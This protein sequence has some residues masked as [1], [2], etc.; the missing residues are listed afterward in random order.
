M[1]LETSSLVRR[2]RASLKYLD[3]D[4]LRVVLNEWDSS[5]WQEKWQEHGTALQKM[6]FV[7][8]EDIDEQGV[9]N[10][11]PRFIESE[12]HLAFDELQNKDVASL[13]VMSLSNHN[14]KG[15]PGNLN[16]ENVTTNEL[17]DA[18]AMAEEI[19]TDTS[20]HQT[21]EKMQQHH[22]HHQ[23]HQLSVETR[24]LL[25]TAKIVRSVRTSLLHQDY[26]ALNRILSTNYSDV[27]RYSTEIKTTHLFDL[28]YHSDDITPNNN[29][30]TTHNT[31]QKRQ[32]KSSK[33]EENKEEDKKKITTAS[34]CLEPVRRG[35][36]GSRCSDALLS[37]ARLM[38]SVK[39]VT[40]GPVS[41]RV[42]ACSFCM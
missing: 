27:D 33:E 31:T 3:Y 37:V 18:I 20:L 30:N 12:I 26:N 2:V 24:R 36:F 25:F 35:P 38:A 32:A 42:W 23:Q 40:R 39:P 4:D 8:N 11:S 21:E 9:N 22:Q 1:A 17:D 34:S 28:A 14:L 29:S 6:N 7:V 19:S 41:S 10:H 15:I 16:L 13:L 5:L